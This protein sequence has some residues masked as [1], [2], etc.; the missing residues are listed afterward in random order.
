MALGVT[1][2]AKFMMLDQ[3]NLGNFEAVEVILLVVRT[4]LFQQLSE[5]R[6]RVV[7]SIGHE[8]VAAAHKHIAIQ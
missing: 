4:K 2:N 5:L 8:G 1:L 3:G 7:T 6:L